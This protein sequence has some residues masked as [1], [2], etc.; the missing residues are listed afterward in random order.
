VNSEYRI[1][2]FWSDEDQTWIAD[3][4]DLAFCSAHGPTPHDAVAEV[5]QAVEAWIR[6]AEA[7]GRPVP[8]PRP[9]AARA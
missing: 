4:P 5:E 9:R 7:A 2:V 1:E 3:V 8:H 6:T